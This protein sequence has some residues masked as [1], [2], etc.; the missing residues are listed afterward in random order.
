MF[1]S[2]ELINRHFNVF[3]PHMRDHL[4]TLRTTADLAS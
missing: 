2:T 4:D 3:E 1:S